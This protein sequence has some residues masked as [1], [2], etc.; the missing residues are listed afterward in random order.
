VVGE[1]DMFTFSPI[2]VIGLPSGKLT[3]IAIENGHRNSVK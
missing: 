3:K 1:K 2:L